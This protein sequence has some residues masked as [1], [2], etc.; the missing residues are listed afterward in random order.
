MA[1]EPGSLRVQKFPS[2]WTTPK[3]SKGRPSLDYSPHTPTPIQA[4]TANFASSLCNHIA[5]SPSQP[6]SLPPSFSASFLRTCFPSELYLVDFPQ[7]LTGLDYLEDLNNRRRR[8]IRNAKQRLGLS[9]TTNPGSPQLALSPGLRTWLK[10]V[11]NSERKAE[12]LFTQLYVALRR[13]VCLQ[14][15]LFEPFTYRTSYYIW[16]YADAK[17]DTRQRAFVDA[18]QPAQCPRHA[19]HF[20][21]SI[22]VHINVCHEHHYFTGPTFG[23]A[24]STSPWQSASSVPYL[25]HG[26]R[27][28]RDWRS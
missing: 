14:R 9:T 1:A 23:K 19:E 21:P 2:Q 13:W 5:E 6:C 7:A 11:E 20:I 25:H 8:D 16:A 4:A 17:L 15:L 18:L 12:A 3:G 24:H 26:R 27:A 28:T 22:A 10:D